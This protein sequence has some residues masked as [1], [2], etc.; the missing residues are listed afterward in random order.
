MKKF[1]QKFLAAILA[2]ALVV[3]GLYPTQYVHAATTTSTGDGLAF[4]SEDYGYYVADEVLDAMP[5][6]FEATVRLDNT[7]VLNAEGNSE[8]KY[9]RTGIIF[10]NTDL[11]TP[12][13]F[14]FGF[15]TGN[16]PYVAFIN[17]AGTRVEKI[18]SS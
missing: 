16:R 3:T 12:G 17:D 4:N 18:F 11:E 6:K 14:E 9:W 15:H 8:Y 2:I 10:S 1:V 7:T 13:T 5:Q